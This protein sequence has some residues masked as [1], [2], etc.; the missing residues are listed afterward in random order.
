[1]GLSNGSQRGRARVRFGE[2]LVAPLAPFPIVGHAF[3]SKL[4]IA[5]EKP[6]RQQPSAGNSAGHAT[7][8]YEY[9]FQARDAYS[10]T[11]ERDEALWFDNAYS[12]VVPREL[13]YRDCTVP[14]SAC[15][16]RNPGKVGALYESANTGKVCRLHR[17]RLG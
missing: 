8:R 3:L 1:M 15:R 14:K 2:V 10:W 5:A 17:H 13:Y 16:V 4:L 6:W 9:P 12:D 11:F 7:S